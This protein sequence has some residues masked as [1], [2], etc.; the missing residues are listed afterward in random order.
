MIKKIITVGLV[1]SSVSSDLKS[2]L[3]K[4]LKMVEKVAKNGAE[5]ICLQ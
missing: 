3:N 1:Q 2:N 5:I 4:T